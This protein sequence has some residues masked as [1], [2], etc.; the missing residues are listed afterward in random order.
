MTTQVGR[1]HALP[2][3]YRAV[4]DFLLEIGTEEIPSA[5][6][7]LEKLDLFGATPKVDAP[8]GRLVVRAVSVTERMA[9][10]RPTGASVQRPTEPPCVSMRT[11]THKGSP[12]SDFPL[13]IA[14]EEIP[15]AIAQLE[16]LDLFGATPKV[17]APPRRLVVR[18]ECLSVTERL[19]VVPTGASMT[20]WGAVNARLNRHASACGQARTKEAR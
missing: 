8:P 19:A 4:T 20:S 13:E 15:S 17:D 7:Q 6:A 18:A 9:V 16:K 1:R 14:T 2:P 12:M 5:I 11:G 3:A 10:V